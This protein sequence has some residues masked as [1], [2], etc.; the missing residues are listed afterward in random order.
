MLHEF[1]DVGDEDHGPIIGVEGAGDD[2]DMPEIDVIGGLVEDEEAGAQQ[3]ETGEGDEAL[4]P[5]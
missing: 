5:F 4:L 3:N 2:G 1:G